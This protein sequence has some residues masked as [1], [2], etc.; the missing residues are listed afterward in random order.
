[1]ESHKKWNGIR[2]R[3][4]LF[5]IISKDN[6]KR[7][8]FTNIFLLLY[9]YFILKV[10]FFRHYKLINIKQNYYYKPQKTIEFQKFM[11]NLIILF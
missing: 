8:C 4:L 10:L 1:M 7:N 6:Y 5:R 3:K 2:S 11:L 9:R